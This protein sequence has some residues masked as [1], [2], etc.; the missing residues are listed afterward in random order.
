MKRTGLTGFEV[1]FASIQQAVDPRQQFLRT[2][3]G[4]QDYWHAVLFSHQMHMVCTSDCAEN[5]SA[6][7]FV[8]FETFTGDEGSTTVRELND[9]R[10][11]NFS[12]SF[13]YRVDGIRADAVNG[14]Q[15]E[16]V[17]FRYFEDFLN[18]I[19][20]D[21]AGFYEIKIL[22]M[23]VSC[24]VYRPLPMGMRS[25]RPQRASLQTAPK[26]CPKITASRALPAWQLPAVLPST[27]SRNAP[28]P[29]EM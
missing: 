7:R 9:D 6:L 12:R 10:R 18:V 1:L 5:R 4:V 13:Q 3:V 21:N 16:F 26:R 19:T 2:V 20:S 23:V 27:N 28:P 29:V 14:W 8:G 25:V 15:S 24:F 22:D 11:F 17:F